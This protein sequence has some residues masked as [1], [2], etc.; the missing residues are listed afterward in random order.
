MILHL[1][2]MFPLRIKKSH[3][4]VECWMIEWKHSKKSPTRSVL[5]QGALPAA[6]VEG[7]G[8]LM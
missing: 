8:D 3:F 5:L 1:M 7:P 4:L 2:Q 6:G